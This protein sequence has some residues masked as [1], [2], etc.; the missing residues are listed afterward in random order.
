MHFVHIISS[1]DKINYGVWNPVLSTFN[2]YI[3]TGHDCVLLTPR[4]STE[5]LAVIDKR[6]HSYIYKNKP[7]KMVNYVS[8]QF[9]IDS[10]III[11]HGN[12]TAVTRVGA[13]LKSLGFKWV[14]YPH[15]MLEPWAFRH[16]YV[17]KVIY[18]NLFEKRYLNKTDLIVAVGKPEFDNLKGKFAT[19]MVHIPNGTRIPDIHQ[20]KVYDD[21]IVFLFMARLHHKKGILPLVKGWLKSNLARKTRFQLLVAGPDE[22]EEAKIRRLLNQKDNIQILGPVYNEKKKV[23]LN[24]AHYYILPSYSEGFPTSIVEAMA[25]GCIPIISKGCNFPEAFEKDLAFMVSP[26]ANIICDRLNT[27]VQTSSELFYEKSE[28][29]YNFVK[30]N[31][32]IES[33]VEQQ[34]THYKSIM[35]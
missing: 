16:K 18:Y 23:V 9:A 20:K 32:S 25:H 21:K 29:G 34:L 8:N 30:E 13:K 5:S 33:I 15:G 2:T 12:W 14:V 19:K 31:Y 1:L 7:E 17:K 3:K 28:A 24:Q 11:T 6:L 4:L 27:I 26:D 22:G 10:T 35:K